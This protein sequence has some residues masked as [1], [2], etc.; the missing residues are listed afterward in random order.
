MVTIV[1][2]NALHDK[3]SIHEL[4]NWLR[5]L[6]INNFFFGDEKTYFYDHFWEII[7]MDFWAI[8]GIIEAEPSTKKLKMAVQRFPVESME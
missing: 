6:R 2:I 7:W 4:G 3:E 8:F 1:L 5:L